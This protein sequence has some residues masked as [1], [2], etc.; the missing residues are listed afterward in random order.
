MTTPRQQKLTDCKEGPKA[1]LS[2][3]DPP[4][5]PASVKLVSQ[6]VR[7]VPVIATKPLNEKIKLTSRVSIHPSLPSRLDGDYSW[8][9]TAAVHKL[10]ISFTG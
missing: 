1:K 4:G 3:E 10:V 6:A 7:Q 8:P 2:N 9:S 5:L